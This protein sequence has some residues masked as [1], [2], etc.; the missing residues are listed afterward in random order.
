VAQLSDEAGSIIKWYD[1]DAFGVEKNPDHLDINV[2]R[3]CCEY[4][5]RETGTIY[6]RAR[7]YDPVIGRFTTQDT[8][9]SQ[10]VKL[11]NGQEIDDPLS[12]NLY[13]YCANN[14]ILYIDSDGNAFFLVT[15]A[16]GAAAGALINGGIRVAQNLRAG[17]QW[18]EGVG[19]ATLKGAV[20]GGAIG[21]TGGMASSLLATA[22]SAT[23]ITAVG[24]TN[25]VLTGLG[26]VG[27]SATGGGTIVNG[28]SMS[29]VIEK[30]DSIGA[31]FYNGLKY[32]DQLKDMFGEKTAN[33]IGKADN[34]LWLINRM[35]Q[36][37]RIVDIGIDTKKALGNSSY[38][39]ESYLTFFYSNVEIAIEYMKG[40]R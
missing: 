40:V 32:Y 22:G 2:F 17:R 10:K 25:T 1:Y 15:G 4:F 29:R 7:Y 16:I 14:P 8:L 30:A 13:T 5:D 9:W 23:G 24:S 11:P 19:S 35:V 38:I 36:N 26:L 18:S 33:V 39:L 31:S 28:Q 3:Y 12:L 34:A 37:Y 6:L 21:L 20:I 27:G